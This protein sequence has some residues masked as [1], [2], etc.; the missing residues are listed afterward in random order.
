ME[1]LELNASETSHQVSN[2]DRQKFGFFTE[3][4][5]RRK[6]AQKSKHDFQHDR[7]AISLLETNAAITRASRVIPLS[8]L[9]EP[10]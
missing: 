6:V 5:D 3:Y 2:P 7:K 8:A 10:K 9:F 4:I 1:S